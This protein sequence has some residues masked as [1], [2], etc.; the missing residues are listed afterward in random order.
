MHPYAEVYGVFEEDVQSWT[1]PFGQCIYSLQFYETD[2]ARGFVRG[3]KWAA[4]PTLGP[5]SVLDRAGWGPV[6][7]R[8]GAPIH[9]TMRDWLGHA[10]E[11]GIIA[12]DLPDAANAVMLD[13]AR[14]RLGRAGHPEGHLPELGEHQAPA[15][16]S[17]CPGQGGGRG[18][19]RAYDPFPGDHQGH[20]VAPARHGQ[21]G[22]GSGDVGGEPV[23]ALP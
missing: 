15:G 2:P 20:R 21:D 23:G 9:A 6:T 3:A 1:G 13:P 7:E 11:F 22:R 18:G 8:W 4:M 14:H 19:R 10:I 12:E 5:L 16:L 17:R